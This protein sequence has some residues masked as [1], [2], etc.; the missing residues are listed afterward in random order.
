M[1]NNQGQGLCVY[2]EEKNELILISLVR[3]KGLQQLRVA[4]KG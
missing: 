1:I 2:V 4:S 3:N